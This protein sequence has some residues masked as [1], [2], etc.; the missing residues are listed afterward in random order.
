VNYIDRLRT[1]NDTFLCGLNISELDSLKGYIPLS[2]E[3][4]VEEWET[5]HLP[6]EKDYSQKDET[7]FQRMGT[8]ASLCQ[9]RGIR[10]VMIA[11]PWWKSAHAKMTQQGIVEMQNVAEELMSR[12]PCIEYHNYVF[13]NRFTADDFNDAT[14]LNE[15]GAP[16]FSKILKRDLHLY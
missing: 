3:N 14:H 8:I 13:D 9:A 12:Y 1:G 16:K 5:G 6:S 4:R 15:L 10:L 7:Y 11:I 2:L